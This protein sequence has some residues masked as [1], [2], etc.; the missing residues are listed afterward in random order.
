MALEANCQI[1]AGLPMLMGGPTAGLS[2]E[3]P[4]SLEGSL[5]ARTGGHDGLSV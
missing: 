4:L 1:G 2:V 3:E 5:T